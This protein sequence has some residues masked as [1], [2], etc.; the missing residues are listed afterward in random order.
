VRI[1]ARI[2]PAARQRTGAEPFI[3]GGEV[4]DGVGASLVNAHAVCQVQDQP[5]LSDAVCSGADETHE[6]TL[7][8]LGDRFLV[9]VEVVATEEFLRSL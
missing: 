5:V 2:A 7:Q 1:V 4:H 8:L 3:Q 9:Q 6:A